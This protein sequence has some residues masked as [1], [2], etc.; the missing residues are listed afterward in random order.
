MKK[1]LAL[2]PL[3]ALLAGGTIRS[4]EEDT[5]IPAVPFTSGATARF[6]PVFH[7][8]IIPA[9]GHVTQVL[10][11]F[12]LQRVSIQAV[13][14]STIG[15]AAFHVRVGFGPPFVADP[16]ARLDLTFFDN[17]TARA[18]S[19]TPVKGPRLVLVMDN[20]RAVPVTLNLGVYGTN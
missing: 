18:G 11:V 17:D 9:G 16:D 5:L 6:F 8:L 2:L 20:E 4:A 1:A 19:L 13:A 7:G 14:N 15:D 10:N 12:N 3:V